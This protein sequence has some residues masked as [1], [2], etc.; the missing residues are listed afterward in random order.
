MDY[1]NY[2]LNELYNTGVLDGYKLII[3]DERSFEMPTE[4]KTLLVVIKRITGSYV[5]N[6]KT[7]PIQLFVY[8]ELNDIQIAF[9]ML[10]IYAKTHNNLQQTI[11]TDL[12]KEN[13]DTPVA[14]RNFVNSAE[15]FRASVYM[16]GVYILCEDISDITD[17]TWFNESENKYE[18]I[19]YLSASIN[20]AAVLHTTKQSG[21]ELSTSMKQEAG[22]TLVI[23]LMHT[24]SDFCKLI[25][26]IMFGDVSGNTSFKFQFNLNEKQR[27]IEMKLNTSPFETSKTSAP[28]ITLTF[29]L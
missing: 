19:P 16:S 3:T 12:I 7:Q 5:G 13:Y 21:D 11:K 23:N 22:L 6:I 14:L 15:G 28:G 18:E 25:D 27:N 9:D 4:S 20:Y 24:N 2:L 29:T 10:D 8:S 26:D 1:K 17:F